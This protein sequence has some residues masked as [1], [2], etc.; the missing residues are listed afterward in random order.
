MPSFW[1]TSKEC[2]VLTVFTFQDFLLFNFTFRRFLYNVHTKFIQPT[3]QST[4]PV[5]ISWRKQE[6]DENSNYYLPEAWRNNMFAEGMNFKVCPPDQKVG[7][8][9]SRAMSISGWGGKKKF[10]HQKNVDF[11]GSGWDKKLVDQ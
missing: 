7:V 1:K 4:T 9:Y 10:L 11:F 3:H 8:A 6:V 5:I 2:L